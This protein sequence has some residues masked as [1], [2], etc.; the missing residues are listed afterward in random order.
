SEYEKYAS[1]E[2]LMNNFDIIATTTETF[3]AASESTRILGWVS[4]ITGPYA[5]YK[6]N[7]L[8]Y[9]SGNIDRDRYE[10]RNIKIVTSAVV[11]VAV[12]RG[13]PVLGFGAAKATSLMFDGVEA[14]ADY[15]NNGF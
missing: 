1:W 9:R 2:N 15:L 5:S 4:A 10:F 13:H 7:S 8:D 6:M 12:G 11:G 3:G 14:A